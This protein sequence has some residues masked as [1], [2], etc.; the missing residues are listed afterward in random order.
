MFTNPICELKRH[1]NSRNRTNSRGEA[2]EEYIKDVFSD[3]ISEYDETKRLEKIAEKF[4][5]LGNQN[6][7]PDMIMR[8]GDAIEV[9]KIES[10]SSSLALNSSYP[11]NKLLSDSAMI[12]EQCRQ[13]ENW[14]QKDILYVVGVMPNKSLSSSGKLTDVCMVYGDDY[15]ADSSIYERIKTT[16]RNGITTIPDVQ[17]SQTHELGR[18]NCVDPLGIT[19]LR[20][21]GMWGIENPWKTFD[22]VCSPNN[23]EEFN[24]F[25]IINEEKYR[26]FDPHDRD[27]IES[28]SK[29]NENF[30]IENIKIKNPNN[31]SQLKSAKRITFS[32]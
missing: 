24:F 15:A 18:V 1:G 26:S 13:C 32:K 14:I 16:I 30:K 12:T 23:H 4:S 9:K 10:R 21:R 22:Y 6:N 17:F 20:I 31:P 25:G 7:P 29:Q 27:N 19:Y 3:T 2:L 5:Y 11:K 8:G 28:L